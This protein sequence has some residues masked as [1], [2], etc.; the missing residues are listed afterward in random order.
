[1]AVIYKR[2]ESRNKPSEI[3]NTSSKD[4]VYIRK[5]IES[6]TKEDENGNEYAVFCYDEAFLTHTEY[7][8]HL[9]SNEVVE[10]MA[11]KHEN[12]IIDEYTLKLFEE[13]IL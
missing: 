3:D 10:N 11:I 13:G 1:M 7:L 8:L 4:G 12:D 5:N 2:V 9:F 6:I